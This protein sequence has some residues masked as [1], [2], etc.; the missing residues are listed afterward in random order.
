MIVEG[1]DDANAADEGATR[2]RPLSYTGRLD[3]TCN[4]SDSDVRGEEFDHAWRH[5]RF[6]L[7]V[8]RNIPVLRPGQALLQIPCGRRGVRFVVA[9][10]DQRR[11][12]DAKQIFRFSTWG[13]VPIEQGI[14]DCADNLHLLIRVVSDVVAGKHRVALND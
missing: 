4:L 7:I 5:V 9:G 11:N 12:V 8:N 10:D 14:A 3:L 6:R 2:H 13:C 1:F